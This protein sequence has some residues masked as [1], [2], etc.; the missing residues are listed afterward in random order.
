MSPISGVT[1]A[2]R[3]A[4]K[5]SKEEIGGEGKKADCTD[6]HRV[7]G[8]RCRKNALRGRKHK[9]HPPYLLFFWTDKAPRDQEF[10]KK[11]RPGRK[12]DRDP[13]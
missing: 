6:L 10:R 3:G 9:V 11:T 1:E 13:L 4:A 5:G 2:T 12:G 8:T 7:L